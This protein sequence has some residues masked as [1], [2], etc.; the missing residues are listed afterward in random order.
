MQ[1]NVNFVNF[2]KEKQPGNIQAHVY[3][4]SWAK[5]IQ[6]IQVFTRSQTYINI[7]R[8]KI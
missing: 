4:V 7:D 8:E 6:N 2:E 1:Y 3:I 5:E